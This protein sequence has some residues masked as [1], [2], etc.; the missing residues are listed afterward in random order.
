MQRRGEHARAI[1]AAPGIQRPGRSAAPGVADKPGSAAM[2]GHRDAGGRSTRGIGVIGLIG[3]LLSIGIILAVGVASFRAFKA[4]SQLRDDLL[5]STALRAQLQGIYGELLAAEAGTLGYVVTGRDEFLAPLQRVRTTIRSELDAVAR[6]SV[7]RPQHAVLLLELARYADQEMRLLGDMIDTRDASGALAATHVME[8]RRGKAVMERIQAVVE[9]VRTA[10][11]AA[12]TTRTRDARLAAERGKRNLLLMLAAS[13]AVVGISSLVMIAHLVGRRRTERAASQALA[14]QSAI[15]SSAMDAIL[16]VNADGIV[17]HA[18]P[19]TLRV[20]GWAP[21]ELEGRPLSLLFVMAQAGGDEDLA[22]RLDQIA[23]DGGRAD[24]L[25]GRRKNGTAFPVDIAVGRMQDGATRQFVTI[26]H[27]AGDRKPADI[28]KNDF[29]STISHE[30]QAP[31]AAIAD[32]LGVLETGAAGPL[33]PAAK[34]LV[35]IAHQNGCRLQRLVNDVLDIEKMQWSSV[36][37][38]RAPVSMAQVTREAIEQTASYANVQHVHLALDVED[39]DS[40]VVGDHERLVKALANLISNAVKFSPVEGVVRVRIQRSG[41]VVQAAV[42]DHGAGIPQA[43]RASMFSRFAPTANSDPQLRSGADVGL[44]I[45]KDIVER[46]AGRVSFETQEGLGTTFIVDLPARIPLI[47]RAAGRTSGAQILLVGGTSA[48]EQAASAALNGNG[49]TV[50]HADTAAKAEGQA[51]IHPYWVIIIA[52]RLRDSDGIA[53]IRSLRRFERTRATPL[54]LLS[55]NAFADAVL[56]EDWF[57]MPPERDR[58]IA[59]ASRKAGLARTG[60][61]LH[62]SKG[63]ESRRAVASGLRDLAEVIHAAGLDDANAIMAQRDCR[64]VIVDMWPFDLSLQHLAALFRF[65]AETH[66]PLALLS[67]RTHD[68]LMARRL[69]QM[70]QAEAGAFPSAAE[71]VMGCIPASAS[72]SEEP[73]PTA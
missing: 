63:N 23:Q 9:Q 52:L 2:A 13:I 61:V 3:A 38:A 16:V 47:A 11:F 15:I 12:I 43:L 33:P 22:R 7:E 34:R 48:Q 73:S 19:A 8:T 50:E 53:L 56:V 51:A 10:E 60:S 4:D 40:T 14:R 1:S 70:F 69:D 29:V 54:L 64:L 18:N 55:R 5:H 71:L 31:L 26:L 17:E 20:T 35:E 30:L 42:Q 66:M 49:L 21:D 58:M 62:I 67:P 39:G 68:P 46:H 65:C 41:E 44:A 72:P 45:V 37:F 25:T 27:E 24:D 6:L 32:A 59:L 28:M 36:S 57:D